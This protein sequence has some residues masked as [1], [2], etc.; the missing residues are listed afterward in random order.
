M[1]YST[2]AGKAMDAISTELEAAITDTVID[3]TYN[4]DPKKF[5]VIDYTFY[6]Y[7]VDY[8]KIAMETL[9]AADTTALAEKLT[10]EANKAKALEAYKAAIAKAQADA[11]AL[12]KLDANA[13]KKAILEL[14]ASEN[15]DSFYTSAKAAEAKGTL[16]DADLAEIKT[17]LMAE[18]VAKAMGEK[19]EA[20]LKIEKDAQT[21]TAYGKTVPAAFIEA[22]ETLQS[23]M[24]G[25]LSSTLSANVLDK[26]NH[27]ADDPFSTW[28]FEAGRTAGESKVIVEGDGEKEELPSKLTYTYVSAYLL[29]SAADKDNVNSR[30]VAYAVFST[31]DAAK[32]AIDALKEKGTFTVADFEAVAD[33]NSAQGHTDVS[34][35]LEGMIGSTTLDAWLFDSALTVGK[36]TETPI[37]MA[38]STYGV[39]FYH[40]EGQPTWKVTVKYTVLNQNFDAYYENMEA[41][42]AITTK[43]NSFKQIDA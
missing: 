31:E 36:Y 35:C 27:V 5:N 19:P 38:E 24:N 20:G 30:N 29:R 25:K 2:L 42:Y 16:T 18:A 10:D 37:L 13:M 22:L 4:A 12:S 1:E 17:A 6:T 26:V 8:E 33:A 14:V 28:A 7:K 43:D 3:D 15:Y 11:D 23:S 9:E 40:S 32:K 34:D 21:G 39:A 41:K